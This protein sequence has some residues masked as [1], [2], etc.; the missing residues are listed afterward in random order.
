MCA[1]E[2][3]YVQLKAANE[4]RES[5]RYDNTQHSGLVWILLASYMKV[6]WGCK[7]VPHSAD[8]QYGLPSLE[9]CCCDNLTDF[10]VCICIV[11]IIWVCT[12]YHGNILGRAKIWAEKKESPSTHSPL[13]S[14]GGVSGSEIQVPT[15][16]MSIADK[17][18]LMCDLSLA[19][20]VNSLEQT[21]Y[22]TAGFW[23]LLRHWSERPA[24]HWL[25]GQSVTTLTSLPY[26][27][28]TLSCTR[29]E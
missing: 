1:A 24:L 11:I 9:K 21:W 16:R 12:G 28:C 29:K 27:R 18:Q 2:L 23:T 19:L 10:L 15:I 17:I 20:R 7:L 14:R 4:A 22:V 6:D 3:S 13:P 8:H 5:V 26:F 25:I